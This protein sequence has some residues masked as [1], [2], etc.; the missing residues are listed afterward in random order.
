MPSLEERVAKLEK[1]LSPKVEGEFSIGDRFNE[2]RHNG[3][4]SQKVNFSDLE[5]NARPAITAPSGGMTVDSEARTAI[6]AI[7][8]EL[9]QRGF[10]AEN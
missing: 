9:E 4:D 10:N 5:V 1:M 7:I 8:T 2:H 6:N 3:Q